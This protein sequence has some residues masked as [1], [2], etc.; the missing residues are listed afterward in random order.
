MELLLAQAD[1]RLSAR[2]LILYSTPD[3]HKIWTILYG[4][5]WILL[6]MDLLIKV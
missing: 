6:E 5:P 4:R 2:G 1:R 3:N